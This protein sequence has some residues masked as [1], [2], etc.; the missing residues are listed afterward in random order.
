MHKTG[1]QIAKELV[2][3]KKRANLTL[4]DA[5]VLRNESSIDS[6]VRIIHKKE[7]LN[8]YTFPWNTNW[9]MDNFG[10]IQIPK[11]G[12]TI[13]LTQ[14]NL[15]FY[16]MVIRDYEKH[17]LNIIG[18]QIRIDDQPVTSYTFKQDY[19]WMMGDNRQNSEDS[20]VWGFVPEDHIVGKPIFIWMSIEGFPNKSFRQWKFRPNRIFS[21]VSGSGERKS[22]LWYF[23][24]PMLIYIGYGFIKK[25]KKTQ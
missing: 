8:T 3:T 22:Y 4:K 5:E 15:P 6:V 20:R 9:T 23:L 1:K 7:G 13:K 2:E 21:T 18:N 10:P 14:E 25:K 11:K 19:Y 24:I 17:Q 16:K 12:L